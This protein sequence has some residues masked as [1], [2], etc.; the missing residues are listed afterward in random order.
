MIAS[1]RGATAGVVLALGLLVLTLLPAQAD[2]ALVQLD[3]SGSL[4]IPSAAVPNGFSVDGLQSN[5]ITKSSLSATLG[6]H[7]SALFQDDGWATGYHGWLNADDLTYEAFVTYDFYGFKTASGAAA[8]SN[9]MLG[10]ALG[11]QTPMAPGKLPPNTEVFVDSTGTFGPQLKPF[12]A[13]EI[14]FY[15]QNVLADVTVYYEGSD[16]TAIDEATTGTIDAA[17]SIGNWLASQTQNSKH[18][19]LPLILMPVAMAGQRSGRRRQ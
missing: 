7:A 6:E 2:E 1:L 10:L 5:P 4:T 18:S 8:A 16:S 17:S 14:V 13:V 15:V 12:V 3:G 11:V 9:M 19:V